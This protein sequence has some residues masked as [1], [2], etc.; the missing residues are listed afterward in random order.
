MF[1]METLLFYM[2]KKNIFGNFINLDFGAF[3]FK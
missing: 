3:F 2:G 1:I